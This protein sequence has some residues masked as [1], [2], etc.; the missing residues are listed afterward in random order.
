MGFLIVRDAKTGQLIEILGDEVGQ[1]QAKKF[2][3]QPHYGNDGKYRS[4]KNLDDADE[5]G[6]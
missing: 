1:N 2:E 4:Q 3:G 5:A 6:I